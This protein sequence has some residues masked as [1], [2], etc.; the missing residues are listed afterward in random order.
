MGKICISAIITTFNEEV[1]IADCIESLLWVDEILVVDSFSTDR[2]LEIAR[3]YPVIIMQREYYGDAAQRNWAMDRVKN[4]W[5][6]IVDADERV[7]PQLAEEIK[8]TL[9]RNSIFRAF[10]IPRKNIFMGKHIRFSGW[11]NDRVI[12][13]VDRR[14]CRYLNKRVHANFIVRGKTGKLNNYLEHYTFRSL[15]H[16]SEKLMKYAEWGAAQAFRDRKKITFLDL[17]V[18]PAWRFFRTYIFQGGFLDGLHGITVCSLQAFGTFMKY[19][20]LW[21]YY[22]KE[23]QGID[24]ELPPFETDPEIWKENNERGEKDDKQGTTFNT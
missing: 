3:N 7:T 13:L 5:V 18:R 14:F 23:K 9:Q 6:L 10:S 1:N 21:E 22:Y 8:E 16:Y 24:P 4:E 12:R 2:T 20:W 15:A 17:L 19:A 11:G